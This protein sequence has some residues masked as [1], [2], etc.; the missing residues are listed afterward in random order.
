MRR[1]GASIL[2]HALTQPPLAR[3][4]A[5]IF[6]DARE[7]PGLGPGAQSGKDAAGYLS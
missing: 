4:E 5:G 1:M 3:P 7:C 2:L 6:C